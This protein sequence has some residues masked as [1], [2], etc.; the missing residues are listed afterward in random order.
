MIGDYLEKYDFEYLLNSAL[1]RMPDDVDKRQGSV[2][3]DT[4]A[5]SCYELAGMFIELR[6]VLL[7]TYI[8]TSYGEYLDKRVLE[9]GIKRYEATTARVKGLFTFESGTPASIQ[10]GSRFSTIGEGGNTS[11]YKVISAYIDSNG[12]IEQGAYILQCEISGTIGNG[13][14]GDLLPIT[15]ISNLKTAK[16]I[17]LITPGRDL[18]TDEELRNRYFLTINQKPFGGNIAQYDEEIRNI[19]GI[20]EVQVYP[21]WNGGG[22]VKCSIIDVEYKQASPELISNVQE[23]IDPGIS[24]KGYGLAPIGHTVTITTP[25]IVPLSINCQIQLLI[26]YQ[27]DQLIDDIEKSIEE[28]LLTLRKNWGISDEQNNYQ[29]TVYVSQIT[30]AILKVTGVANVTN[31]GINGGTDLVLRQ[32]GDIQEIPMLNEVIIN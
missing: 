16:I 12:V 30:M 3:Y 14:L 11:N 19:D 27:V 31:V 6:Q 28:Y 26:G 20:G 25:N 8:T 13:Y 15:Y 24:G 17:S 1:S 23:I 21:T 10:I 7:N 29:L 4:L 2:I 22:T 5:P 9:Q 32:D 18:E